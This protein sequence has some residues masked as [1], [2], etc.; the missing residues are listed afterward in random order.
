MK[1]LEGRERRKPKSSVERLSKSECE[2]LSK[3]VKKLI[4]SQKL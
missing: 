2:K 1:M 4:Y 3:N